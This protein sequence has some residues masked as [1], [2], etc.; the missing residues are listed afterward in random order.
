M[1]AIDVPAFVAGILARWPQGRV[2]EYADQGPLTHEVTIA[3]TDGEALSVW[4]LPPAAIHAETFDVASLGAFIE[5]WVQRAP[6]FDPD[7]RIYDTSDIGR[8]LALRPTTTAD[9][10]ARFFA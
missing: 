10:V 5:W 3:F 7:L 1:W 6:G 2:H 4:V 8:S 9:D